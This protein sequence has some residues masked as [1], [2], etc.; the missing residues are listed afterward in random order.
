MEELEEKEKKKKRKEL[1]F[2]YRRKQALQPQTESQEAGRRGDWQ[3]GIKGIGR[4]RKGMQEEKRGGALEW[5]ESD[6]KER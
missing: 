3:G 6:L 2:L 1:C 5:A 4:D